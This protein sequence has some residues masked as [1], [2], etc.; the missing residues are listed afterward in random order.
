MQQFRAIT[1]RRPFLQKNFPYNIE[2]AD[3]VEAGMPGYAEVS[4]GA[5][6]QGVL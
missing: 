3:A 1:W 4:I 5:E 2:D 6:R